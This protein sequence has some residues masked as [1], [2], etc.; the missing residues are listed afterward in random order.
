MNSFEYVMQKDD[1]EPEYGWFD[2]NI[3]TVSKLTDNCDLH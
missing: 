3:G 2:V 1:R